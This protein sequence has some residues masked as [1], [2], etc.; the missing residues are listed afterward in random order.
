[1]NLKKIFCCENYELWA[2]KIEG[3]EYIGSYN[4]MLQKGLD[5]KLGIDRYR[6]A[7]M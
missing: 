1:M 5:Y 2:I 4:A 6:K 7:G 3:V